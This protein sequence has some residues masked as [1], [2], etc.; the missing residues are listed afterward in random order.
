MNIARVRQIQ[1]FMEFS[2]ILRLLNIMHGDIL[3]RAWE[4]GSKRVQTCFE[5][6]KWFLRYVVC[7]YTICCHLLNFAWSLRVKNYTDNCPWYG[8][9]RIDLIIWWWLLSFWPLSLKF[10]RACG[11]WQLQ[12]A[13]SCLCI[14]RNHLS[15][16]TSHFSI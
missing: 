6:V 7:S 5:L 15:I 10:Y 13:S 4:K 9:S 12:E 1:Y 11:Y 2:Q 14:I 16:F 8:N 3:N